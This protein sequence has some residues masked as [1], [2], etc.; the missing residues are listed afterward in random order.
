[1]P[2][3]IAKS[4]LRIIRRPCPTEIAYK[5]RQT[6]RNPASTEAQMSEAIATLAASDEWTDRDLARQLKEA[7]AANDRI[8]AAE[9]ERLKAEKRLNFAT[10]IE[11]EYPPAITKPIA[12][13]I[14]ISIV[15]LLG[16]MAVAGTVS[17]Q[18]AQAQAIEW[19]A[20]L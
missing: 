16:I 10:E 8:Y 12:I 3:P 18:A 9:R 11:A 5:A 6:V 14:A 4:A 17:H 13:G 7:K 2:A 15:A 20:S 1:M 19:R